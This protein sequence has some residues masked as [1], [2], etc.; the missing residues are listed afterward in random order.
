MTILLP[1][2]VCGTI[3]HLLDAGEN[4]KYICTKTSACWHDGNTQCG[5]WKSTPEAAK[6]DWNRRMEEP[7]PIDHECTDEIVCPYCGAKFSDDWELE[8]EQD[9][10]CGECG[11]MFHMEP[12]FSVTYTT[13]KIEEGTP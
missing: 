1:C 8:D 13:S 11:K 4:Y 12:T 6:V 10:E 7:I 5:D 9:V 2:R 3:P